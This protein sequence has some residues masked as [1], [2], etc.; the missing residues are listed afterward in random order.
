MN[1]ACSA[2]WAR[3]QH[4]RVEGQF[5]EGTPNGGPQVTDRRRFIERLFQVVH[6]RIDQAEE[7]GLQKLDEI[8]RNGRREAGGVLERHE[9][10]IRK[11]DKE[12]EGEARRREQA[13]PP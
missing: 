7:I 11:L 9:E 5:E 12:N 2:R 10:R 1:G 4:E 13:P 6:E 8:E 3:P